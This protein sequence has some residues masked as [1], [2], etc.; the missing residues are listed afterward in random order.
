M[1]TE[2][3]D[4]QSGGFTKN[5]YRGGISQKGGLGQFADLNGG[6]DKK[7]GGGVFEEG[8]DAS[9]HTKLHR[10]IVGGFFLPYWENK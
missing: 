8:V 5:Q 9:M 4:F 10:F 1:F 2:K 3:S 6:L 7:E